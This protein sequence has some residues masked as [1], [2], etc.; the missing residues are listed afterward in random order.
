MRCIASVL[1]V[2]MLISAVPAYA[3]QGPIA[4]AASAALAQN[5]G[6]SSSGKVGMFWAGIALMGAGATLSIL[7]NTALRKEE[8]FFSATFF[9]CEESTPKGIWATGV[10]MG[11]AGAIL[12]TIG[13]SRSVVIGPNRIGYRWAF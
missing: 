6:Q 8:C 12:T 3:Q 9:I 4:A 11:A 13:A 1:V 7:A 10:A 2:A 5:N